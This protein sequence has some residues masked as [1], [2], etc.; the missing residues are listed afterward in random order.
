MEFAGNQIWRIREGEYSGVDVHI[1]K[2]LSHD[3][4]AQSFHISVPSEKVSHMPF[5][6]DALTQSNLEFVRL[7]QNLGTD[8]EEGFGIWHEAFRQSDAGVFSVSV[9]DAIN[10]VCD[11]R[12]NGVQ[13]EPID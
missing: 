1:H 10:L 2:V 6:E 3:V 11:T 7:E 5:S 13:R 4:I 8:W 9:T 12:D